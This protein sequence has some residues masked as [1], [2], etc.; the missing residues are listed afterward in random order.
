VVPTVETTESTVPEEE[1][2]TMFEEFVEPEPEVD[3]D[4]L[5]AAGKKSKVK[6]VDA[7][8][9]DA[10]EKTGNVPTNPDVITFEQARKLGLNPGK[11]ETIRRPATG[12]LK[13][14]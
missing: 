7:F 4:A 14:K 9:N 8:W 13:K 12:S 1:E 6:D 2:A 11:G 5:F 10:V 3:V